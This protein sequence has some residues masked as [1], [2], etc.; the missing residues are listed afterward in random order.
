[1]SRKNAEADH[2]RQKSKSEVKSNHGRKGKPTV[3]ICW[4]LL[5]FGN[6]RVQPPLQQ[7]E[8]AEQLHEDYSDYERLPQACAARRMS[9]K[10]R[11]ASGP[12]VKKPRFSLQVARKPA[13]ALPASGSSDDGSLEASD[14]D[15]GSDESDSDGD[16]EESEGEDGDE[17]DIRALNRA[18]HGKRAAVA[19]EGEGEGV[20]DLAAGAS[21]KT[22][23]K[24]DAGNEAPTAYKATRRTQTASNV[25]EHLRSFPVGTL[26]PAEHRPSYQLRNVSPRRSQCPTRGSQTAPQGTH[27][28]QI[29][30]SGTWPR[31][32]HHRRL[33]SSTRPTFLRM[34]RQTLRH[35][36][37]HG[38]CR[39]RCSRRES[40]SAHGSEGRRQPV[41]RHQ[42]GPRRCGRR[43]PKTIERRSEAQGRKG[44][45]GG[46][47]DAGRQTTACSADGGSR[48]SGETASGLGA[49]LKVGAK[50]AWQSGQS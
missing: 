30:S 24:H 29:R 2:Q 45:N 8:V 42:S 43:D 38:D 27:R 9:S 14:E 32:G 15:T 50:H 36:C 39:R 44:R 10:A 13:K 31:L 34:G 28:V 47:V 23:S 20:E 18:K 46:S 37:R 25:A 17:E 16:S 21:E 19:V 33:G 49:R 35:D 41:Q 1:M 12:A 4:P 3:T 7:A 40:P 26:V 6:G 22:K 5:F 11:P 48:G